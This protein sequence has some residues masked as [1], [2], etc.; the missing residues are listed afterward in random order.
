MNSCWFRVERV[1][2]NLNGCGCESKIRTWVHEIV[3]LVEDNDDSNKLIAHLVRQAGPC[4][5]HA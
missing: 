3:G 5:T 2:H 1:V 4:V